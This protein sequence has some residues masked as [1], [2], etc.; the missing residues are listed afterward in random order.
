MLSTQT[1][2]RV[3]FCVE[4]AADARVLRVVSRVAVVL[5]LVHDV[6]LELGWVVVLYLLLTLLV[7]ANVR[8]LVDL[9]LLLL[10]DT[11]GV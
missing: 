6:L 4:S 10:V 8:I 1:A 3:V 11:L 2:H 5:P 7:H 9:L